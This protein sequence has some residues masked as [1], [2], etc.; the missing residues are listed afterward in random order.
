MDDRP[1]GPPDAVGPHQVKGGPL[2]E[3]ELVH[4][5]LVRA[6]ID[7]VWSEITRVRGRQRA[8]LDA[9]LDTTFQP[10]DP[11]YYRSADGRRVLIV[12]RVVAVEAPRRFSHTQ[13]LLVRDDPPTLVTWELDEV[14]GGTRVTLR[15]SGWPADT[16][17]LDKVDATWAVVLPELKKLV[18]TGDVSR[19]RKLRYALH[20]P[21][22]RFRPAGPR[23]EDVSAPDVPDRFR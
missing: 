3:H 11:L 14:E 9:V 10:G 23:A 7:E 5:I 22:T 17:D 19:K 12:G 15:H 13:Q 16:D 6:S 8:M 4:S 18:E 2:A 20:R 1:V 21:L